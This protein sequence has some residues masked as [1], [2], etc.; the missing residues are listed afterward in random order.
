M[1]QDNKPLSQQ[2][3]QLLW[4][5]GWSAILALITIIT[6]AFRYALPIRDGDIWFHMLYGKYFL[7]NKTL[8]AD[9][10]IFSW[11]PTTNDTIYNTWLPD[12]FWYLLYK[13]TGLPGIFSFRYLCMMVPVVG[14]FLYSRSLKITTHP[15]TWLLCILAVIMS[16]TAAF[17]KPEILS[18]V[19][20]TLLAWNWWH[21]RSNG[22]R[23]WKNCYLFPAIMLIWVNSHGG[24]V[25]GAV[26]L[27][28]AG[29]GELLNTW[30]GQGNTLSARL[31]RHL[32]LALLLTAVMPFLTPYGYHYP[33]QLLHDLL[34]T[35]DNLNYIENIS[36]YTAPFHVA[37]VYNHTL[38]ANLAIVLLLMLYWRNFKLIEW[39]SLLTNLLFAFLYTKYLRTTFYWA[40]IFLFSGLSLL[41]LRPLMTTDWRHARRF[42]RLL[43]GLI[44]LVTVW[45][46]GNTLYK[47]VV[48]PE[49]WLWMGF[50]ISDLTPVAEVEYVKKYYPTAR[51]GNTYDQ[52]AYLLWKL[53]PENEVFF[54]SRHFPF[55]K[56]SDEFFAFCRGQNV[57]SF[58]KK[59][60][61]DLWCVGLQYS[62][63]LANLLGDKEWKLAFYGKNAAVLVRRTLPLPEHAPRIS[64][65][66]FDLKNRES[67]I[68]V[69]NFATHIGDFETAEK[70][71]TVMTSTF[72]SELHRNTILLANHYFYGLKAYQEKNYA[73]AAGQFGYIANPPEQIIFL[74]TN[75]FQFLTQRAWEDNN[76]TAALKFARKALKLVPNNPYSLFNLGVI[77]WLLEKDKARADNITPETDMSDAQQ[78]WRT[79]LQ[80]FLQQAQIDESFAAF[81][82]I[83]QA[84]LGGR[85]TERPLL[86]LPAE[87]IN[88]TLFLERSVSLV[89]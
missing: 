74:L 64:S 65:N 37:D 52:G 87:P 76:P 4:P 11:T 42:H 31:R 88:Q 56:L 7:E 32:Y 66:L 9:H 72:T 16:Y 17:D 89:Q 63:L 53:W 45:L 86:L 2:N 69:F 46:S 82:K 85:Q 25:F 55:R 57:Q 5:W 21:I 62:A 10:T 6:L 35:K 1:K 71:L 75:C 19:F 79:F 77:G 39:S 20:M 14:C 80:Q 3:N 22:Q 34:P 8:I 12:I 41:S 29:L 49:K 18:Y 58:I 78:E 68:D 36:A 60:P 44:L 70:L 50:G 84:I 54:D 61:C 30:W 48:L 51:V 59:Y 15:L 33:L 73:V 43:P 81:Q 27:F 23:A 28:L 47:A 40:P 24:F 13:A 38:S 83:A 26:F 67:A